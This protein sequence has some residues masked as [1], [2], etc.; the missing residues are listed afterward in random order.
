MGARP[1]EKKPD[2]MEDLLD[3]RNQLK[4]FAEEAAAAPDASEEHERALAEDVELLCGSDE[5]VEPPGLPDPGAVMSLIQI[6]DDYEKLARL[7]WRRP[8]AQKIAPIGPFVPNGVVHLQTVLIAALDLG[9]QLKSPTLRAEI[10][11]LK[12]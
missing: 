4:S 8:K 11:R 3:L 2:A 7:T 6:I 1:K 5:D 9:G 10:E 12:A